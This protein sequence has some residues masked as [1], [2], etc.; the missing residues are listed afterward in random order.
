MAKQMIEVLEGVGEIYA[1]DRL[2]RSTTYHLEVSSELTPPATTDSIVVEG[3]IDINGMPEAV[4]LAGVDSLTLRL[5]DG[6]TVPF[7]L[8]STLGRIRIHGGLP[9]A[10]PR[11]SSR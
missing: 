1:G 4:V 9:P 6:R 3:R 8:G 5:E 7:T 2:L 11:N 10:T